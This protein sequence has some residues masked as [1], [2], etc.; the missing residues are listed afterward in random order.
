MELPKSSNGCLQIV[1]DKCNL[2]F[3]FTIVFGMSCVIGCFYQI[4]SISVIYFL[5]DTVTEVAIEM[6]HRL[7]VPTLSVC[8]HYANLLDIS[9]KRFN[10]SELSQFKGEKPD[11]WF[12]QHYFTL[13]GELRSVHS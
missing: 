2:R 10:F 1:N 9:G 4:T 12:L 3:L 5:Y 11:A 6:P 7:E 13:K 8:V